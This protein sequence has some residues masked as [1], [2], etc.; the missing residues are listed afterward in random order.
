MTATDDTDD[1]DMWTHSTLNQSMPHLQED[2]MWFAST[3][4]ATATDDVGITAADVDLSQSGWI[5]DGDRHACGMNHQDKPVAT[6]HPSNNNN[7]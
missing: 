3:D 7:N 5:G 1:C 6:L 2:V 4:A